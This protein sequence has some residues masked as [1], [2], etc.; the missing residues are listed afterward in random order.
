MIRDIAKAIVGVGDDDGAELAQTGTG[1]S[2]LGKF[3]LKSLLSKKDKGKPAK[4]A[5][6]AE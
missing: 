4:E 3:D 5:E 6:P 2:L 1:G